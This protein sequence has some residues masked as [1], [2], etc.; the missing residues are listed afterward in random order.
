MESSLRLL[1]T[2]C[3]INIISGIC[4]FTI[5]SANYNL[6]NLDS[7]TGSSQDSWP[8]KLI[9]QINFYQQMDKWYQLGKMNHRNQSIYYLHPAVDAVQQLTM[10]NLL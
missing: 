5:D 8:I 2:S 1:W 3:L 7:A 9:T 4:R 10:L 6:S